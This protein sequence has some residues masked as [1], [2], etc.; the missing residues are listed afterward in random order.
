[1]LRPRPFE[2]TR[3]QKIADLHLRSWT[4]HGDCYSKRLYDGRVAVATEFQ[5]EGAVVVM[6]LQGPIPDKPWPWGCSLTIFDMLYLAIHKWERTFFDPPKKG[7]KADP[8][9]DDAEY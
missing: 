6:D 2:M 9:D 3:E 1:M 7:K 4:C 5:G 8:D